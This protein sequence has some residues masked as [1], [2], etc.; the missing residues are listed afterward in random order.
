[1]PQISVIIVNWN[2]KHFLDTCLSAMRQQTFR[3]FETLLV[4]NGSQDGS[5]EYV[6]QTFPEVHLIPLERNCGFSLGNSAGY[7]KA[8]GELIALLNND[9][10]AGEF[11]LEELARASRDFPNAGSFASKMLYFDDRKR[12][13]N[14]GFEVTTAGFTVDLG[15]R[16]QDGPAWAD[17]RPVFGACGGAAAYRRSMLE[18]VGFLDPDFFMTYEDVDLS[19]Q[20]QLRGH[21]CIFVPDAIVYHR[22]RATMKKYWSPSRQAFFSQRNIEFVHFTNMPF[23]LMLRSLPQ[24]LIYE[25]GGAVYALKSGTGISFL[26]AKID[27][28]R[29]LP[30]IVRK[31]KLVQ[32]RKTVT[33]EQLR[34]VMLDS[35]L[36]IGS[37]WKKLWSAKL[38]GK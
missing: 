11:W 8:S 12:I 27:A 24:R 3:N 4:D 16:E 38:E 37:K 2:G 32:S 30:S 1:M 23:G 21:E 9:T 34:S 17:R 18:D 36:G 10:E 15:R 20:A 22:Y 5:V 14:C 13:D 31:R 19:F 29:H 35:W 7:A 33:D 6:R 28:I 25:F 26:R